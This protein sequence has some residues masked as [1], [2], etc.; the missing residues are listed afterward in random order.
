VFFG[1]ESLLDVL[2][3]RASVSGIYLYSIGDFM[4]NASEPHTSSR[5]DGS[6]D[7]ARVLI[8][9]CALLSP[10]MPGRLLYHQDVLIA[11]SRILAIGS[12]GTLAS[13]G[14]DTLL[15][16]QGKVA[17]PGLIN[18]HTHSPENLLKATS[19]S[20]PL[21]LWLIPLFT[22]ITDWTPRLVYLSAMLGAIEMLKS[23]TTA[24]LDHLWTRLCR[25]IAMSAFA[26]RSLR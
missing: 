15:D 6:D 5:T 10:D 24:V 21:E 3:K 20:L 23:G 25:R 7:T 16:G 8:Q 9:N 13:E 14:V 22:G 2:C 1:E 11:G 17:I 19:P 26:R 4:Q 12:T 18:A